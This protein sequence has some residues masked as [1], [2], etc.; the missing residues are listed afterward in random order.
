[1]VYSEKFCALAFAAC[2]ACAVQSAAPGVPLSDPPVQYEQS[3]CVK[4][5]V[6]GA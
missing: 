4:V 5:R 3:Y 6:C 2:I 1:M